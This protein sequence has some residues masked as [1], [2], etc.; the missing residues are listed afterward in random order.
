MNERKI[1]AKIIYDIET[2][3][4]YTNI[5][6]AKTFEQ[7]DGLS[8]VEKRLI[9]EF[10]HGV[11]ERRITLDYIISQFSS[12]KLT[13]IAP[14]VLNALRLGV[15][16]LLYMDKIPESAAVNESVKIAKSVGGQKSGGFV[17]AILRNILRNKDDIKY[18][19]SGNEY[20]SVYYSY[21]IEIIDMFLDEFEYD[22]VEEMLESFNK[23][24]K[25]YLR[26]NIT[27]TTPEKLVSDLNDNGI[28]AEIY[29]NP[30]FPQLDY[31]VSVEKIGDMERLPSYRNGDFYIQDIASALVT[32]VL[33][34]QSGDVVI[35][36]CAAPG[37]KTT[38]IAEKMNNKGKVYAFDIY[39]HKI[40]LIGEN[41]DRLGL[42][43]CEPKIQDA[44]LVN[45]DYINMADC[46][47]V[48]APCSGIGIIGKKPDIK[49]QRKPSDVNELSEIGY[50]ILCNA[51]KYVKSGG[52]LVYS[53]CTVMK[54]ENEDNI[55]KFL[56][57]F[58][59][60]FYL[61]PITTINKPNNGYITLYPHIDGT[62]GFFM[63]RLKKR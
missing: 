47:L 55:N 12:I 59:D 36:M 20:L 56:D 24:S 51:A 32:E 31:I 57:E 18:P 23:R 10:V 46:V 3:G 25:L 29:N 15:Y 30:L 61:E 27:K 16:Q 62:D 9:S 39:E 44:T 8:S 14:K 5:A 22:F 50:K 1:A 21:P 17:N 40:K 35:D 58:N 37:G 54:R 7:T 52:T 63:C 38:H 42:D 49:Y 6:L 4:A 19:P 13:K 41:A 33:N 34:P 48:D 26:C 11:T 45:D 53:T 2:N 60:E 28:K 43:I